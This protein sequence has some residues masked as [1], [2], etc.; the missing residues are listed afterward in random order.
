MCKKLPYREF[1]WT[2]NLSLYTEH[3]I[4]NYKENSD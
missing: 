3:A 2:R 4:K 1:K